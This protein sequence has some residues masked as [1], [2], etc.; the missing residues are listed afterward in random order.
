M[1][2]FFKRLLDRLRHL[3]LSPAEF[4]RRMGARKHT[5]GSK[6]LVERTL[7]SVCPGRDRGHGLGG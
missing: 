2:L 7:L 1:P 3:Q 4:V 6:E 5:A